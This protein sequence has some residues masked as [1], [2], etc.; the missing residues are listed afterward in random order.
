MPS[1]GTTSHVH[2]YRINR[3]AIREVGSTGKFCAPVCAPVE[4]NGDTVARPPQ[5]V[6]VDL[7]TGT[8]TKTPST[9]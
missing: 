4:I 6:M 1:R 9:H 2:T 5:P 7:I 3:L 8:Y